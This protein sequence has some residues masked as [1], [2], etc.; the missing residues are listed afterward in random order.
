[1]MMRIDAGRN[2]KNELRRVFFYLAKHVDGCLVKLDENAVVDLTKTQQLQ[3]LLRGR[4]DTIDT[5]NA[6]HKGQLG[7]GRHIEAS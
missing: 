2:K 1:M 3:D 7:L 5:T 6:H 4:I